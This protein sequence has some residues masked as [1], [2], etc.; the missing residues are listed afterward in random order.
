MDCV[1]KLADCCTNNDG[2]LYRITAEAL[3][4]ILYRHDVIIPEDDYA[5]MIMVLDPHSVGR[6]SHNKFL[7]Q[8]GTGSDYDKEVV[9]SSSGNRSAQPSL[10]D[11]HR[12]IVDVVQS[13]IQTGPAELRRAFKFF[14]RSGDGKIDF[15]EFNRSLERYCGLKFD[16][17][18][19]N[20][21][22]Q[23]FSATRGSSK[24]Q[25]DH[26]EAT[27]ATAAESLSPRSLSLRLKAKSGLTK[28]QPAGG[29]PSGPDVYID[30]RSFCELLM[31]ST[32][33][34][35]TGLSLKTASGRPG[36]I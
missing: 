2:L 6:V 21:L 23:K 16:Q 13:K 32:S 5:H 15:E 30:Y 26:Y 1:L 4:S 9:V 8:F 25:S 27:C 24:E 12:M 29:E 33:H 7:K 31:E 35:G 20:G 28:R 3:R 22:F 36:S 34:S 11:A 17:T 18:V 10:A 19:V 14:D